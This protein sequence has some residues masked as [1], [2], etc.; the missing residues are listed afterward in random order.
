MSRSR[1]IG[2]SS[3][4][5]R[6]HGVGARQRVARERPGRAR[7]SSASEPNAPCP[8][9]AMRSSR[10]V[11][12]SVTRAALASREG[13]QGTDRPG[14]GERSPGSNARARG[15]RER[16]SGLGRR[17]HRAGS[18]ARSRRRSG[19]RRRDLRPA[20]ARVDSVHFFQ[21]DTQCPTD[22]L[23]R[24]VKQRPIDVEQHKHGRAILP[25]FRHARARPVGRRAADLLVIDRDLVTT[26]HHRAGA[27][28]PAAECWRGQHTDG[29]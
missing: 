3:K 6:R 22:R 26:P 27:C 10:P 4:A 28:A 23:R 2:H 7:R 9:S 19:R 1:R 12:R 11:V 5:S 24:A 15:R 14:A 21:G 25:T 18:P 29:R 20:R 8:R 16:R 13:P 17:P